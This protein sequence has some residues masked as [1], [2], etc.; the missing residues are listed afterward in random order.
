[1]PTRNRTSH[2]DQPTSDV[3][4]EAT[5]P[6]ETARRLFLRRGGASLAAA[7]TV[8]STSSVLAVGPNGA[9][10]NQVK[11]PLIQDPDT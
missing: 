1:M 10:T 9:D 2:S 4:T 7:L 11:L 8:G 6:A 3:P 5:A